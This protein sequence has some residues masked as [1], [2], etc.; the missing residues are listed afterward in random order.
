MAGV[1]EPENASASN[2][3]GTG[4]QFSFLDPCVT[5]NRQSWLHTTPVR[6]HIRNKG[7][8]RTK[9]RK[10]WTLIQR[11]GGWSDSRYNLKKSRLLRRDRNLEEYDESWISYGKRRDIMPD[12]VLDVVRNVYPNPS[13]IPYMGHRWS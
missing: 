12:C 9:N 13:N 3:S 5:E 6:P 10:F 7:I 8:R 2:T 4:C 1:S 11:R